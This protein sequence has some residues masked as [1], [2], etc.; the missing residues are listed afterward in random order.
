M[1]LSLAPVAAPC[2]HDLPTRPGCLCSLPCSLGSSQMGCAVSPNMTCSVSP[3]TDP[4]TLSPPPGVTFSSLLHV[5]NPSLSFNPQLSL[6]F[7]YEALSGALSLKSPPFFICTPADGNCHLLSASVTCGHIYLPAGAPEG[8]NCI[9]GIFVS[10][11]A[12][13]SGQ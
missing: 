6:C 11:R 5:F 7:L 4:L 2:D 12:S 10:P 1:K 3:V 9:L 13:R 8:K